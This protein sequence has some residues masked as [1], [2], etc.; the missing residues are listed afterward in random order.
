M[1][2]KIETMLNE[3]ELQVSVLKTKLH[4]LKLN[5]CEYKVGNVYEMNDENFTHFRIYQVMW[6]ENKGY[7]FYI[8]K[9]SKKTNRFKG[10][11]KVY[12]LNQLET[13][14]QK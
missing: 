1:K 4:I 3:V 5:L 14:L 8:D 6:S 10:C 7:F 2:S 12:T 13:F 11:R 9:K